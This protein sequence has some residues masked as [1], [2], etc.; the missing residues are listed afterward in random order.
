SGDKR[1]LFD[2]AK[3]NVVEKIVLPEEDQEL[4]ESQRL[5]T[6]LTDAIHHKDMD[7][8]TDAKAEVENAQREAARKREE[9]GS[10][11]VP[12]FFEVNKQGQ[13]VPKILS[14]EGI[15][16][17]PSAAEQY[18]QDWIWATPP[19]A[20]TSEQPTT[21]AR[22]TT[23]PRSQTAASGPGTS[24]SPGAVSSMSG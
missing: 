5:W 23:P 6:K 3:E 7:A 1:V 19:K 11:H 16:T 10:K 18:V 24:R 13:W 15:P 17:D 9:T 4:N 21:S 2:A 8:A 14:G 22:P 20:T 12:R